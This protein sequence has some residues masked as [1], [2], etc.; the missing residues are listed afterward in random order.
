MNVNTSMDQNDP[1]TLAVT[2]AALPGGPNHV[3]STVLS[4]P[5]KQIQ[6]KTQ[7]SNY[8]KLGS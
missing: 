4:A 5:A 8:Q 3:E 1:V 2:F 7:N 6:V